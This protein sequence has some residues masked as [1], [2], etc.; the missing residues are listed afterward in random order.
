MFRF[1]LIEEKHLKSLL[2]S[3]K[4][5]NL[6]DGILNRFWELSP[7]V[8]YEVIRYIK[9]KNVYPSLKAIVSAFDIS[10]DDAINLLSKPYKEFK[11][12]VVGVEDRLIKG[13]SI[14]G[15]SSIVTNLIHLKDSMKIIKNYIGEGFAIFF[16]YNFCGD[17]YMLPAVLSMIVDNIPEDLVFTGKI[18]KKGRIY[19]VGDLLKKRNVANIHGLRLFEPQYAKSVEVIKN[20]LC[21]ERYDVP[22]YITKTTENFQGE[23]NNFYSCLN[24]RDAEGIVNMLN[25]IN[26]ISRDYLVVKTGRLPPKSKVWESTIADI[27]KRLKMIEAILRGRE[28]IHIAMNSPVA[29]VFSLGTIFGDKKPFVVY[30]H[31]NGVYHPI[32]MTNVRYLRERVG[33]FKHISYKIEGKGK[34]LAV[35]IAVAPSALEAD[36]K[37]F[38]EGMDLTYITITHE[39]SGNIPV[40]EMP[41]IARETASLIQNI[42][43]ER[44][45]NVLHFFFSSPIPI[46]FMLGI[47]LWQFNFGYVYNHQNNTYRRVI[48]L[49]NVRRIREEGKV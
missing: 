47:A 25:I 21:A 48:N 30:H 2:W 37:K 14:K 18:D 44:S 33:T 24:I 31:Q 43:D 40:E 26:G 45:F 28:V 22:F 8:Q 5:D 19:E 9:E 20:W 7:S 16:E 13:I 39:R 35:I 17:S 41:E 6:I 3:G 42:K 49:Q 29:L 1:S 38:T 36:V 34:E 27:Y 4:L 32:E 10:E 46:A 12:P 11:F 23:I 15:L